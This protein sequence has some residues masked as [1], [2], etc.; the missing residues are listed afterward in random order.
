MAKPRK[1]KEIDLGKQRD[2][3]G[4]AGTVLRV[5]QSLENKNSD[6]HILGNSESVGE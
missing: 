6:T 4:S 5:V 1:R 2:L 3:R